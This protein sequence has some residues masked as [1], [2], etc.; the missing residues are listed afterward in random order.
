LLVATNEDGY[1]RFELFEAAT[2]RSLGEVPVPGSG[3]GHGAI[4]VQDPVFS[5]EGGKLGFT[6][7]SGA[8]IPEAWVYDI[9]ARDLRRITSS[10]T[11][12]PEDV[13]VDAELRH[14][15]S[16]DGER[17]SAYVFRDDVGGAAPQPVVVMV[18]GGPE[19]Q[20]KPVFDPVVQYRC[21]TGTPWWPNVRGQ[22]VRQ[23][24]HHLDDVRLRLDSVADLGALRRLRLW[25]WTNGTRHIGRIVRRVHGAGGSSRSARAVGAGIDIVGISNWVTFL[26]NTSAW[27]RRFRS[28]YGRWNVTGSSWNRSHR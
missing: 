28:E 24:F 3:V 9:E 10:A 13:L 2:L 12:L 26:E 14:F 4:R 22:R 1:S 6:W 15:E 25:A 5:S 21:T 20:Y 7:T 11:G 27:R 19:S 17:V 16:F 8:R 23:R 18:H